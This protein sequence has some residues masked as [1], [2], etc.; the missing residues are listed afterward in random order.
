VQVPTVRTALLDRCLDPKGW[1]ARDTTDF[2]TG[3]VHGD[4]LIG[5]YR[6]KGGPFHFVRKR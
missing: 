4:T 2:Y 1:S 3:T 6:F 5:S